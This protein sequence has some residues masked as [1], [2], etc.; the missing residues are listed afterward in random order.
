[1]NAHNL[2]G[3]ECDIYGVVIKDSNISNNRAGI[4]CIA[5]Q[6]FEKGKSV[7]YYCST[8]LNCNLDQNSSAILVRGYPMTVSPK[9][10]QFWAI[11][12]LR[13]E[14]CFDS[15]VHSVWLVPE[16]FYCLVFFSTTLGHYIKNR[17][18]RWNGRSKRRGNSYV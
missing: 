1:M 6:H 3:Y 8:I 16:I 5:A 17:R 15:G 2:P 11:E 12:L 9:E 4:S 18:A 10:A 7:R 13:K 14:K